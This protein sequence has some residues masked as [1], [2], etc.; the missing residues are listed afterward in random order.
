MKEKELLRKQEGNQQTL[1]PN[2]RG[3]ERFKEEGQST[4]SKASNAY[5]NYGEP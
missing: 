5:R 1:E 4:V 3:I 2:A